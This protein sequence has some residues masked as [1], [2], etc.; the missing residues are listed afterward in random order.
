MGLM[1]TAVSQHDC[2]LE[3]E[4]VTEDLSYK[5]KYS[6]QER[7]PA[8]LE[9]GLS[10]PWEDSTRQNTLIRLIPLNVN[11]RKLQRCCLNVFKTVKNKTPRW[12]CKNM[13]NQGLREKLNISRRVWYMAYFSSRTPVSVTKK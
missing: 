7:E 4:E 12:Q 11:A 5:G 13:S 2:S 3:G 1:T 9:V 6:C 10:H 8:L